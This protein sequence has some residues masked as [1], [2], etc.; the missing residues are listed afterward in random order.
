MATSLHRLALPVVLGG[1]ALVGML[2]AAP[3]KALTLLDNTNLGTD[4]SGNSV[5]SIIGGRSAAVTFQTASSFSPA[6][7][8]F[9]LTGNLTAATPGESYLNSLTV[10]LYNVGL[11]NLPTGAALFTQTFGNPF[12]VGATD[13]G[14]IT[15]SFVAPALTASTKY[16]FAFTGVSSPAIIGGDTVWSWNRVV[17]TTP[18]VAFTAGTPFTYVS[19]SRLGATGWVNATGAP[20]Y[21]YIEGTPVPGPLPLLGAGSAFAWSRRLR[22]RV[23]HSVQA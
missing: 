13:G 7:I 10:N 22:R 23:K 14:N 1:A 18:P 12:G 15:A 11:S 3:A 9:K 6:F 5:S 8:S 19:T 2:S 4:P 20:A 17:A 21:I 16:A